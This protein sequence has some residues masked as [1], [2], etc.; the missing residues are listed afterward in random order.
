MSLHRKSDNKILLHAI[1]MAKKSDMRSKHGAVLLDEKGN[2]IS[3]ACN[4]GIAVSK[5]GMENFTQSTKI[6]HHA[7]EN[8]LR[9]VDKKKLKGARLYVVRWGCIDT[10]PL[11]MNSKPCKRCTSIIDTCMKKHGLKVV[12]YST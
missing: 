2:I 6:S 12:Y 9:N 1:E 10:N 7:E 4:K 3:K 11:L 8:A 5:E